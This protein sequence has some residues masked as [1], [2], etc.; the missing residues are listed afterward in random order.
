MVMVNFYQTMNFYESV[1]FAI[2]VIAVICDLHSRRIPNLL[3][4]GAAFAGIAI[5][6]YYS[7]ISGVT[8]ALIGWV[9]G[10]AIFFPVFALGGMGGGDIKLL[11]AMGAWLGPGPAL[12]V[13]LYTGIAGGVMALLVATLS[14]YLRKAFTNIWLLLTFWRVSGIR[15]APDLMLT[16]TTGPRLA[17][18][19]PV[20]AGLVVTLW[21]R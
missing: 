13:A 8:S 17:Y 10:A 16:T 5:H 4:F 9:A 18:A 21:L 12:I 6:G 14:G 19:L 7:G 11:G 15:P 3:T 2:A 20:L 1:A